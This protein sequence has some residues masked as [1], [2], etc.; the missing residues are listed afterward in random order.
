LKRSEY[1]ALG[2]VG[3]LLAAT[4]WPRSGAAPAPNDPAIDA[5]TGSGFTTLAFAS[6]DE[7]RQSQA[8]T[9]Q[10]CSA[11]FGKAQ[12]QTV[13]DAPKYSQLSDCEA[14]YGASQCRPAT[15]NG[16]SV[17]IP[18]LA[19]VLIARSLQGGAASSQPL[20]PARVG[21]M[22]C[23]PGT[24]V[25][26]R[27]ECQSRSASSGSGSSGSGSSGRRYY[28]TGSGRVI[29]RVAGAV[30]ADIVMPP[31]TTVSRTTVAPRG[32]TFS[33]SSGSWSS[34]SA[35]TTSRPSGSFSPSSSPTASRGGFGSSGRSFSSS[36]S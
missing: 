9:E 19:G 29:G 2:A 25:A 4:F 17:F 21:A 8:V 24:N 16:A 11:E 36:S 35:T 14:E 22:S 12:Q 34:P 26:D 10:V 23:P 28:S 7:C 3:V 18:A 1:I 15:W 5:A 33:G 13:A 20:Y 31:R 32:G 6:L 30:L 27:P